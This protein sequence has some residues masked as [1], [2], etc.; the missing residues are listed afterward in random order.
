MNGCLIH[1]IDH[2]NSC[3]NH[4]KL[5]IKKNLL[6]MKG[7]QG[8]SRSGSFS[9]IKHHRESRNNYD[10]PNSLFLQQNNAT[11]MSTDFNSSSLLS[12]PLKYFS[13]QNHDIT[14]TWRLKERMKTVGVCL[15]LALN[16]GTDPPDVNRP[17]PCAKLQ[18]WMDPTA[19]SRSKALEKIGEKL[20]NQYARWQQRVKLR[21]KRA[22]DPTVEQVR[23][24]CT[25]MR[26]RHAK[27]ERL[28]LHYNG[29][30]VPRPTTNGEI[31][32]FDKNHTQYIPLNITD[33]R[34]YIGRPS[35][36][37]L[38]CSGAGVLI[39]F[40]AAPFDG[41]DQQH[42]QHLNMQSTQNSTTSIGNMG[43][44]INSKA[45][46]TFLSTPPP[47]FN[48]TNSI[49]SHGKT[50]LDESE[51]ASRSVRDCIVLCPCAEGELLPMNPEFPADIFTSCLT[52]P[53]PIAL[54][55]FVYQNPLSMEGVD[56]ES[57]DRIPGKENDRK[58]P[59]GELNWIF[60]AITDTIAWNVL[61]SP[62][63]QRLFRQDLLVASMFR[64]FLLADRILRSLNCTPMS[65]PSL[66]S[67]CNH[68]LWQA[69]DLAVETC[70][71]QLMKDGH[72][73][74]QP[75]GITSHP[76]NVDGHMGPDDTKI[77]DQDQHRND[78]QTANKY[79]GAKSIQSLISPSLTHVPTVTNRAPQSKPNVSYYSNITSPFF[80]EQLTAFEIWLEFAST[81]VQTDASVTMLSTTNKNKHNGLGS[82]EQ[83][84]VVLQVL[85]SQAHRVRALVLL[86]SF[87]DLGPWAVNLALSVGI[88]PYVLK[89]LKSH[90]DEYK[91]VLV[92]IWAKI[93]AFDPSCQADLVKD[94]ALEHFVGHLKWGLPQSQLIPRIKE[95]QSSMTIMHSQHQQS[96]QVQNF[97][98][99]KLKD[100][101]EQRTMAAFI[102]SMIC[103]DYRLGQTECLKQNLHK[104]CCDLLL[105]LELFREGSS[106]NDSASMI[107]E[108][109][110]TENNEYLIESQ[111][112]N[113]DLKVNE[114]LSTR[115][116][117]AENNVPPQFRLWLCICLGNLWRDCN[118]AQL[119]AY[120]S[121][122]NIHKRVYARLQDDNPHVRASA[123]YALGCLIGNSPSESDKGTV[124]DN[125][126]V[127]GFLPTQQTL[128]PPQ[129]MRNLG[130]KTMTNY[131]I[132]PS[133]SSMENNGSNTTIGGLAWQ[134]NQQIPQY[135]PRGNLMGQVI[136]AYTP[137]ASTNRAPLS[138]SSIL[139]QPLAKSQHSMLFMD[140]NRL[141]YDLQTADALVNA[142][143]D[144][145]AIVRYE[146]I[147]ALACL[148]GKYFPVFAAVANEMS[149]SSIPTTSETGE[150][151]SSTQKDTKK[152]D[153]FVKSESYN[154]EKYTIKYPNSLSPPKI[155]KFRS[156][157]KVLRFI[158]HKDPHPAPS[159][160]ANDVVSVVHDHI[161]RIKTKS[162]SHNSAT[163]N[164]ASGHLPSTKDDNKL[165]N[166]AQS[167]VFANNPASGNNLSFQN[168]GNQNVKG[169]E[170]RNIDNVL[171]L[172]HSQTNLVRNCSTGPIYHQSDSSIN[173]GD[174]SY[175]P[176]TGKNINANG[177]NQDN[178]SRKSVSMNNDFES[179]FRIEYCLPKSAFLAWKRQEFEEQRN[180][181]VDGSLD[182]LSPV[183]AIELYR[184]RRNFY[185]NE[186]GRHL[187]N[188]FEC[189]VPKASQSRDAYRKSSLSS[190]S[191]I[192]ENQ[193]EDLVIDEATM[194]SNA[195]LELEIFN[196]KKILQLRQCS[197]LQNDGVKM[198]S[199]LRF[200]A[201]EPALV[202][203]DGCD[204]ISVFDV[205]KK[206]SS[207]EN[208]LCIFK[209]GNQPKSRMTSTAWINE[210]SNTMLLVASDD[211]TIKIWDDLIGN[212]GGLNKE[213]P[214]LISSF[215]A[216]R[217][218]IP[219]QRG[220][221]LVTEWQQHSGKLIVG[222]NSEWI[223]CWDLEAE[224]CV[225][226]FHRK[227]TDACV[228]TLTTAWDTFS[229]N[230]S[231]KTL[232]KSFANGYS[233][234]GP[235]I[236][237][238]G[239]GNGSIK[240]FDIRTSRSESSIRL[241]DNH[242]QVQVIP[243]FERSEGTKSSF[244]RKGRLMEYDEH[245]SWIVN[246]LFTGYGGRYEVNFC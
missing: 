137:L 156:I 228:T 120:E 58:T 119:E 235:N 210:E 56:P 208:R 189:L 186:R 43:G 86:K 170:S 197:L 161:L 128:I 105:P 126:A 5:I 87:L 140:S 109:N 165:Y 116:L 49:S 244:M 111:V 200:H 178:M 101:A 2:N 215:Y 92:G 84:P 41:M 42:M 59:L 160:A 177:T 221:G 114:N 79:N 201:Y 219:G 97:D 204:G 135:K 152:E 148:V 121:S 241:A 1:I 190:G 187:E 206:S 14:P 123:A 155:E 129:S 76:S 227:E 64:N 46:A 67:T 118:S 245:K 78:V 125:G 207:N 19:I 52:T 166:R 239:Y 57:V 168:V 181:F 48:G 74:I 240:V 34:Q 35:I 231:D 72:L 103:L 89:L 192:D 107:T 147:L 100:D 93:L 138:P 9:S 134:Q 68:P 4:P 17:T 32:L 243:G 151:N 132:T 233:G 61:P 184:N 139:N 20:E 25:T 39:P 44:T 205:S 96:N 16:I 136:P 188:F 62:L 193:Y 127:T 154:D 94:L 13:V 222:G 113:H 73:N 26:D 194:A 225:N 104:A 242:S 21:Y 237:V 18:C 142:T 66:P 47:F 209:N 217:D 53:I 185:H 27:N 82:P 55:W 145:S 95:R 158:Q 179:Q 141:S 162:L 102:L 60:T 10:D 63:F 115:N 110:N 212:G 22:L 211:G 229:L 54:R 202:V 28:L 218:L 117:V 12:S 81:K 65:L 36:L 150:P 198:T 183:G 149:L 180:S 175:S 238:A 234:I 37:V 172:S 45:G 108:K 106:I 69:W 98:L 182:P 85:L 236:V 213:K 122:C 38:D 146:V 11:N 232:K 33:M 15:V 163:K 143:H 124:N 24:L 171:G 131:R 130:L 153:L 29:H 144:A 71:H 80:A 112:R 30:G 224:K 3:C 70:L 7:K 88:F 159:N 176:N 195:K 40:L 50:N 83:L 203:C 196:K 230:G 169:L 99:T 246:T 91:H 23:L 173:T 51:L 8:I 199:T 226:K 191:F 6:S 223:T 220:S 77:K 31:W 157:W 214:S 164:P 216:D 75:V 174:N 133:S 90:V 167:M